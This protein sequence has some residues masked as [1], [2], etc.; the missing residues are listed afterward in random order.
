LRASGL[1]PMGGA[2][3]VVRDWHA[4]PRP[5]LA[6]AGLVSR[7]SVRRSFASGLP[8]GRGGTA[9]VAAAGAAAL[10]I[11]GLNGGVG[12]PSSPSG[13][14]CSPARASPCRRWSSSRCRRCSSLAA[15]IGTTH[16]GTAAIPLLLGAARRRVGLLRRFAGYAKALEQARRRPCTI[17]SP[18]CR[19]G[20]RSTP[21]RAARRGRPRAASPVVNLD[22]FR[23]VTTATGS[24]QAIASS[25]RRPACSGGSSTGAFPARAGGDEFALV[26]VTRARPGARRHRSSV[27]SPW[28]TSEP[29][30]GSRIC[31]STARALTAANSTA[32]PSMRWAQRIAWIARE[33]AGGRGRA[34]LRQIRDPD[35][36]S[37][38][39]HG[40]LTDDGVGELRG[41]LAVIDHQRELVAAGPRR[42][43]SALSCPPEHAGRRGETRSPAA[44][45]WLCSRTGSRRDDPQETPREGAAAKQLEPA[46]ERAPVSAGR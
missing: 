45:P 38:V 4:L 34:V 39:R 37:D 13:S 11:V 9:E 23:Y 41:A 32:D 15:A 22:G 46:V 6:V 12:S 21:A 16:P 10:L 36:G 26:V 2:A 43:S 1:R 5:T 44:N 7:R 35:R 8:R 40:E 28:R 17:L 31:R 14:A 42:K 18:P 25:P 3:W 24:P 27:S 33:L 20:A 19:T 29:R 30:S